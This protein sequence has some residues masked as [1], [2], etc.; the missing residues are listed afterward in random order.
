MRI[1]WFRSPNPYIYNENQL[2]V[3]LGP[4]FF[5]CFFQKVIWRRGDGQLGLWSTS[6]SA[7]RDSHAEQASAARHTD[8]YRRK[9]THR[10]T[11]T[12][13]HAHTRRRTTHAQENT[14]N[15]F[16][17]N[18]SAAHPGDVPFCKSITNMEIWLSS[19]VI[20]NVQH[21]RI[22]LSTILSETVRG[23]HL[24]I[25]FYHY[26]VSGSSNVH[27][28]HVS[29]E[30]E[31]VCRTRMCFLSSAARTLPSWRQCSCS[32]NIIDGSVRIRQIYFVFVKYV[33][34]HQ[35]SS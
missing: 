28:H 11:D 8:T 34:M 6:E 27:N 1:W 24:L 17:W 23:W 5:H 35:T 31:H 10:H 21:R 9:G 3:N 15:A 29:V 26:W 30:H 22:I 2:F 7:P 19:I 18:T 25:V 32:T 20:W 12:Q 16:F 4:L 14:L 13:T 33:R